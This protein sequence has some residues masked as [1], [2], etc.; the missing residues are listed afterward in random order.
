MT[1]RSAAAVHA[2]PEIVLET[3]ALHIDV[4]TAYDSP[5]Y[6]KVVTL[7]TQVDMR[8]T[9]GVLT[10]HRITPGRSRS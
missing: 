2:H 3:V 1:D 7:N 9:Y 4:S 5:F 8:P 10:M 6:G